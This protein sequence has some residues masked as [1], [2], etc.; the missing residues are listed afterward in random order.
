MGADG[1]FVEEGAHDV[2]KGVALECASN[3]AVVP[4]H[5]L[6]HAIGVVRRTQPQVGLV[7]GVPGVGQIF[8]GW[9]NALALGA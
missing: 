3:I 4:V 1:L 9:V 8:D 2:A 7:A 5:V 6:Q